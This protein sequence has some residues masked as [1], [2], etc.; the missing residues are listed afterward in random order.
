MEN[1][2]ATHPMLA[3]SYDPKIHKARSLTNA[4]LEE[5]KKNNP[6]S[7]SIT[8]E[9]RDYIANNVGN[10]HPKTQMCVQDH[11]GRIYIQ[12]LDG[13]GRELY[14][15]A[16]MAA[17][18]IHDL[19]C[20][21]GFFGP[22]AYSKPSAPKQDKQVKPVAQK[23]KPIKEPLASQKPVRPP[24]NPIAVL[25][26]LGQWRD[27][28]V[29]NNVGSP[30]PEGA[31]TSYVQVADGTF[32]VHYQRKRP[33][34]WNTLQEALRS[35][36]HYVKTAPT[37][38]RVA[39]TNKEDFIKHPDESGHVPKHVLSANNSAPSSGEPVPGPVRFDFDGKVDASFVEGINKA[40]A[41]HWLST[42][43]GAGG[44]T[45]EGYCGSGADT[46]SENIPKPLYKECADLVEDTAVTRSPAWADIDTTPKL[47][48]PTSGS[49]AQEEA[50]MYPAAIENTE[51]DKG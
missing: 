26:A 48:P 31:P 5:Y 24:L 27:A 19:L 22:K 12:R 6:I 20:A 49:D 42:G 43:V 32:E 23:Q 40:D 35:I 16:M 46:V 50:A 30:L 10:L 13:G 15:S 14:H 34:S 37:K 2:Q 47:F 51:A 18:D 17:V 1:T 29:S 3:E 33:R 25:N 4:E 8:H 39:P 11:D 9:L 28:Y 38:K 44:A 36:M 45:P 7:Y 41:E 21:A